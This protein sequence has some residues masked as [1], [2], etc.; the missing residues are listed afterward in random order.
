MAGQLLDQAASAAPSDGHLRYLWSHSLAQEGRQEASIRQAQ[1]AV[2]LDPENSRAQT[3]LGILLR[4]Q[5][6]NDEAISVLEKAWQST[7]PSVEAGVALARWSLVRD[8]PEESVRILERCSALTALDPPARR[9]KALALDGC[10]RTQESAEVW[11]ELAEEGR[12]WTEANTRLAEIVE[13]EGQAD[14]GRAYRDCLVGGPLP[15]APSR[16]ASASHARPPVRSG[17]EFPSIV[18]AE[19]P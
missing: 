3:L 11:R 16:S 18:D 12:F 1:E 14:L 4:Q 17:Q 19:S 6:R 15:I 2:R 13:S 7:P 8:R 9:L 10:G 5:G